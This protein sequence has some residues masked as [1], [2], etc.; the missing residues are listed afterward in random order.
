MSV[1]LCLLISLLGLCGIELTH[2]ARLAD[3]DKATQLVQQLNASSYREREQATEELT[4]MG[5]AALP[6]VMKGMKSSSPEIRSRCQE[7][8]ERIR[9]N[10]L[11]KWL[12]R[13]VENGPR[14]GEKAFGGWDRF[15]QRVGDDRTARTLFA[16][17]YKFD[18]EFLKLAEENSELALALYSSRVSEFLNEVAELKASGRLG[19][20]RNDAILVL[21]QMKVLE[22]NELDLLQKLERLSG[23]FEGSFALIEADVKAQFAKLTQGLISTS[24]QIDL[25]RAESLSFLA[26]RLGMQ[27]V[28]SDA[29]RPAYST[30]IN[31]L[32]NLT[33]FQRNDNIEASR[34]IRLARFVELEEVVPLAIRIGTREVN[35][36]PRTL[37][38]EA[39][40]L[41][42]VGK[43]GNREQMEPLKQLLGNR[44]Y[45]WGHGEGSVGI[46][47]YMIDSRIGDVA[48]AA[49]VQL[50]GES[51]ADYGFLQPAVEDP[52]YLD[53]QVY[54][55][56]FTS[57]ERRQEAL[58]RWKDRHSA[59]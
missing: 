34:L 8:L 49:M 50:S 12:L 28:L 4:R 30:A 51:L 32:V 48:L 26:N 46:N 21:Q 41:Y 22:V 36:R 5:E 43:Y 52:D 40:A 2:A 53:T 6:A 27:D 47:E 57:E 18:S 14:S 31:R 42:L 45:A 23:Y 17:L 35:T 11:D 37:K 20:L 29:V 13:F 1:R 19:D 54:F 38:I 3:E 39:I 25:E 56:G 58:A 44:I 9:N 24:G 33:E 55:L 7:I 10:E 15:K 59:E 16:E